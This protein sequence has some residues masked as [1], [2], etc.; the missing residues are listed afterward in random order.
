MLNTARN[1]NDIGQI[2]IPILNPELLG[3]SGCIEATKPIRGVDWSWGDVVE[4]TIALILGASAASVVALLLI[5]WL[6]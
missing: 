2:P 1:D 5:W 3:L 4:W 6:R